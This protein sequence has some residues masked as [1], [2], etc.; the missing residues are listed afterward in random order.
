MGGS[1]RP[2]GPAS[3]L[4]ITGRAPGLGSVGGVLGVGLQLGSLI[5]KFMGA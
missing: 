3:G 1:S 2:A 5:G 4:G